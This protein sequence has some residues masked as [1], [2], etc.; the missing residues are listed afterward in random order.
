VS[1]DEGCVESNVVRLK[2][3][4]NSGQDPFIFK[5][6]AAILRRMAGPWFPPFNVLPPFFCPPHYYAHSMKTTVF[7]LKKLSILS[8]VNFHQLSATEK[9][10]TL[11]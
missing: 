3:I 10:N 5:T 8:F 6:A 1:K 7:L 2:S 9:N 4:G 11:L